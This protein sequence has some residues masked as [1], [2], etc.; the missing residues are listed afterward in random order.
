MFKTKPGKTIYKD[1]TVPAAIFLLF[2]NDAYLYLM[3]RYNKNVISSYY[4]YENSDAVFTLIH[5]TSNF[6][7]ILISKPSFFFGTALHYKNR[8]FFLV[9]LPV[10][11]EPMP[12]DFL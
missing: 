7:Y 5:F 8:Y 9:S 11:P 10:T 12:Q 4:R 3:A 6:F 1:K 2:K